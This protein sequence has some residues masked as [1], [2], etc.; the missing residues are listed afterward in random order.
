MRPIA[1]LALLV[2][3]TAIGTAIG[4][5][6]CS[7]SSSDGPPS[8]SDGRCADGGGGIDDASR[9]ANADAAASTIP[10]E[11]WIYL[12]QTARH[13]T[14]WEVE[15]ALDGGAI[16][17]V[18][19]SIG[20]E[21][22]PRDY[23]IVRV[24]PNGKT[25][26][27]TPFSCADSANSN[28][29][30]LV[31][32]GPN[33]EV[34]LVLRCSGSITLAGAAQP[35]GA[36]NLFRLRD[37]DGTLAGSIKLDADR[38]A[39]GDTKSMHG[40]IYFEFDVEDGAVVG[41]V[42]RAAGAMVGAFARDTG[43]LVFGVAAPGWQSA[44]MEVQPN[45]DV[46]SVGSFQ[47]TLQLG[48][49]SVTASGTSDGLIARVT[50]DG[51]VA[52]LR[53]VGGPLSTGSRDMVGRVTA[54]DD[55]SVYVTGAVSRGNSVGGDPIDDGAQ[56]SAFFASYDAAGNHRWSKAHRGSDPTFLRGQHKVVLSFFEAPSAS[57]PDSSRKWLVFNEAGV[58]ERERTVG[59]GQG[60]HL[61]S[62]LRTFGGRLYFSGNIEYPPVTLFG[63]ALSFP[64]RGDASIS[65]RNHDAFAISQE[66]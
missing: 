22:T 27:R 30:A 65:I 58:L 36:W 40:K 59:T 10:W 20:E 21:G 19:S 26:W 53:A 61:Y 51:R 55:G 25:R 66:P 18:R 15:P 56:T 2:L 41:G 13:E 11:P 46:W 4:L 49:K 32:P 42:R 38:G 45:G 5:P 9:D 54:G 33:G 24:E 57:N 12:E 14:A 47:G 6:G 8:C 63:R 23:T 35:P 48:D 17:I 16:V 50:S 7:S 43:K 60:L 3:P 28:G 1:F 29:Y 31:S 62:G 37:A 34:D 52:T 64:N 44:T 39:F